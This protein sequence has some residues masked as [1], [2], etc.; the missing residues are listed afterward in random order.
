[1]NRSACIVL[2]LWLGLHACGDKRGH[3]PADKSQDNAVGEADP[4]LAE[5]GSPD[6]RDQPRP[7]G[8]FAGRAPEMPIP[9]QALRF[10]M[11]RAEVE[12]VVPDLVEGA[13]TEPMGLADV[14]L[15]VGFFHGH[16]TL[17]FVQ[18]IMPASGK[19][20]LA[21]LWG[22]PV[23]AKLGS[24]KD[25]WYWQNSATGIQAVLEDL[26]SGRISLGLWPYTPWRQTL[27]SGKTTLG[28]EKPPLLGMSEDD[29]LTKYAHLRPKKI[30]T[31]RIDLHL[32]GHEYTHDHRAVVLNLRGGIVTQLYFRL[33]Y[34][35][36]PA[37]KADMEAALRA[38]FGEPVKVDGNY[39]TWR[40]EDPRIEMDH[41]ERTSQFALWFRR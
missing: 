2:V 21:E 29:V 40:E 10:D 6:N 4:S 13:W 36:H 18:V 41:S 37:L 19:A 28:F 35:N 39:T 8:L 27:G 34:G 30:S 7:E 15:R 3:G 17:R 33:H 24:A 22:P 16:D 31:D 38:K 23:R 25:G 14:H 11:P 20:L 5:P 12:L 32:D 1:M 9:L 26:G